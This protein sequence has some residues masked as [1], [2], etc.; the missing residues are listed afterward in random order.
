ML[1]INNFRRKELL[2]KKETCTIT[3]SLLSLPEKIFIPRLEGMKT[4]GA[5][6]Y[7]DIKNKNS[8]KYWASNGNDINYYLELAKKFNPILK[9]SYFKLYEKLCNFFS[10]EFNVECKLHE[11]AA[12]P[13]FHIY[14]NRENF[15]SQNAHIPHFDGQY[16]ELGELFNTNR[17]STDYNQRTLS[18]TLPI[19][20]PNTKCGMRTWDFHYNETQNKNKEEIKNK[21]KRI[22][23]QLIDYK[24]GTM[25]YHSGKSLHQIKSWSAMKNEKPRITLQGHGILIDNELYL[26][27]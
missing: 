3:Q 17:K 7:L 22:K 10:N 23:P 12:L 27:W 24:T 19:S 11:K 2:Q 26:Y 8:A 14:D 15:S 25:V 9:N 20:L 1:T 21:L 5:A 13:G 6:S 4:L 18:F 16:E